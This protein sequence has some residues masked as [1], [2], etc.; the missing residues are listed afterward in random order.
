MTVSGYHAKWHLLG[1]QNEQPYCMSRDLALG[2]KRS[3]RNLSLFLLHPFRLLRSPSFP[4][5]APTDL[6]LS[7][8]KGAQMVLASKRASCVTFQMT[9]V[10][11]LM[12][13][14]V[15][16]TWHVVTLKKTSV[17][18]N[19]KL[20][21]SLTGPEGRVRL[22]QFPQ[23]LPETTPWAPWQVGIGSKRRCN[24]NMV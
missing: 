23:D 21:M 19:S 20:M 7:L 3:I 4:F 13:T 16:T 9:A 5:L 14:H 12:K 6:L 18:G 1:T 8:F 24:Q 15:V 2:I 22:H 17:P 10:I 11:T